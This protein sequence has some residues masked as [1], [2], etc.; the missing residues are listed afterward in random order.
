MDRSFFIGHTI[1]QPHLIPVLISA[2]GREIRYLAYI[3][4][5]HCA[6]CSCYLS[7]IP[8]GW[9]CFHCHHSDNWMNQLHLP[10]GASIVSAVLAQLIEGFIIYRLT[11]RDA[12]LDQHGTNIILI[13][14]KP[15]NPFVIFIA[16]EQ[17]EDSIAIDGGYLISCIGLCKPELIFDHG[18]LWLNSTLVFLHVR[19][20]LRALWIEEHPPISVQLVAHR[21]SPIVHDTSWHPRSRKRMPLRDYVGASLPC[22]VFAIALNG[23]KQKKRLR[24]EDCCAPTFPDQLI[25]ECW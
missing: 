5:R 17:V 10:C 25:F 9:N 22:A 24:R 13:L 18:G 1:L 7:S 2:G 6:S 12:L 21:P 4:V 19:D 14:D 20:E 16:L 23:V 11:H 8:K 15:R 3:I